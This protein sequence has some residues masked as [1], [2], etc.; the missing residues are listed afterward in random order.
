MLLS[1]GGWTYSANF[2]NLVDPAHQKAFAVSAVKIV[3]DYGLDGLDVDVSRLDVSERDTSTA[4]FVL[5]VLTI[6]PSPSPVWYHL[7]TDALRR[8]W[9]YP[10]NPAEA[11]AYT[12]L[13]RT[14][15]E[16][17]DEHARKKDGGRTRFELSVS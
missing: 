8:Q 5:S 1:I 7:L 15:R 12:S 3:E 6:T 17:L 13:L 10:N 14:I 11:Q 9:E 4:L 2:P 16:E